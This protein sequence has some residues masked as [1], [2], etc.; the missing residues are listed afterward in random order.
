LKAWLIA[1][2]IAADGYLILSNAAG[3]N[4]RPQE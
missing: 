2:I 1:W 4:E 3:V